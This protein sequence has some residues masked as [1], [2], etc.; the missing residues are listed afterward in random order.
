V[1]PADTYGLGTSYLVWI[2][3]DS[4]FYHTGKTYVQLYRSNS[5]YRMIQLASNAVELDSNMMNRYH[6]YVN[7]DDSTITVFAGGKKVISYEAPDMIDEG[8]H[9]AL[10]TLGPAEFT[11]LTVNEKE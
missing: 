9:V 4:K 7:H 11:E 10:R 5:Y 8:T 6:V 2:T 3:R 1:K